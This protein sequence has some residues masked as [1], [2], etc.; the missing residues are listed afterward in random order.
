V[1][2]L[3]LAVGI[4]LSINTLVA[5]PACISEGDTPS[6]TS[7]ETN[8]IGEKAKDSMKNKGASQKKKNSKGKSNKKSPEGSRNFNCFAELLRSTKNIR[9]TCRHTGNCTNKFKNMQFKNTI[10]EKCN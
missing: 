5:V 6:S 2:R 3:P 9:R 8:P 10:F 7:P 1:K 4:L